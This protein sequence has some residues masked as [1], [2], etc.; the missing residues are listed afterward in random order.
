[1]THPKRPWDDPA[2]VAMGKKAR[3]DSLT[4]EQR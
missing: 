2:A 1:M 4:A 3:A